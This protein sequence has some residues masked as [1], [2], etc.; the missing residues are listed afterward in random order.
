MEQFRFCRKCLTRD[1]IDK[2]AYFATLRDM[3]EN[4]DTEY[5]TDGAVYEERLKKCTECERLADGMC[6]AC[7]CYVELRAAVNKNH[8]PYNNW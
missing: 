5:K 6:R 4:I 2:D 8:C 3:I 7:G 1:M